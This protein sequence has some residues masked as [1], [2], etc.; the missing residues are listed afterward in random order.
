MAIPG[1]ADYY[2][3]KI[4]RNMD[5]EVAKNGKGNERERMWA[6][7]T[8]EHLPSPE[9]VKVLG[10]LLYDDR[11]PYKGAT[12][13]EDT[14]APRPNFRY[15]SMTL[16]RLGIQKA[17]MKNK[18]PDGSVG[19][20]DSEVETWKVW[21]EQVKAGTRTFSFEGDDTIY[22][23]AGRT[24]VARDGPVQSRPERKVSTTGGGNHDLTTKP[25]SRA[26]GVIAVLLLLGIAAFTVKKIKSRATETK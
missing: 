26:P 22:N 10:E 6:F 1:Y 4:R 17:P 25:A 11:D 19:Y 9:T 21:Y 12:G 3:K 14:G 7:Q 2:D 8:L 15:A 16:T 18:Y 20:D 13:F 24:S 23:L 5:D